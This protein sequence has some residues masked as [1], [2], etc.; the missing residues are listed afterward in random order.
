MLKLLSTR[1][2]EILQSKMYAPAAR[3]EAVTN[4]LIARQRYNPPPAVAECLMNIKKS[5]GLRHIP[6]WS[7]SLQLRLDNLP[8]ALVKAAASGEWFRFMLFAG[9]IRMDLHREYCKSR[10]PPV[11]VK[12]P[13]PINA[14]NRR[15]TPMRSA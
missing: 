6:E 8:E 1:T 15:Y 2:F 7:R 3:M 14:V 9:S 4:D 13:D 10:M 5:L 11:V 12:R